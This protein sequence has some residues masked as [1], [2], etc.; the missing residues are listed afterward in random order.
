MKPNSLVKQK[1]DAL[2]SDDY[3]KPAWKFKILCYAN[4][5][6]KSD[7][8]LLQAKSFKL[9]SQQVIGKT[10]LFF[11]LSIKLFH[12]TTNYRFQYQHIL[13][14]QGKM[15]D[16][17]NSAQWYTSVRLEFYWLHLVFQSYFDWNM[18]DGYAN[19]LTMTNDM[20]HLKYW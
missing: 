8:Q 16:L 19:Y 6:W 5:C 10:P 18:A 13:C 7:D 3:S 11:C 9:H 1:F 15:C 4:F 12:I 14:S 17:N 2:N 20:S